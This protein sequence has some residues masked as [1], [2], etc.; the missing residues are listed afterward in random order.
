[1][2]LSQLAKQLKP[3]IVPW[4]EAAVRAGGGGGSGGGGGLVTHALDGAYHTGVLSSNK[5]PDALLVSGARALVSSLDVAAGATIDGVDLDVHA[6][7]P[8]A[9]HA[10][11]TVGGGLTLAGQQVAVGAGALI[12]V[13]ANTVG[14]SPGANFQF[15]G[16]GSGI[17]AGWRNVS[18]LAGNGLVH[19]AGVLA[20]D[21]ANTG[22]AGLSVEADVVRLTSSDNPGAAAK[23]LATSPS[24]SLQLRTLASNVAFLSGF[25]GAGYRIDY[26]VTEAGK[27]SAEFDNLTVRGRMRVYEL[28]I[29][30]IRATNGSVFVASASKAEQV[31]AE[32]GWTVNGSVLTF[33]GSNADFNGLFYRVQ[34]RAAADDDS[35]DLYHGFLAGDVI[36]AQRFAMDASGGFASMRQSNLRVGTVHSLW[37]YTAH[38][39]GGDVPVVTDDFVR[40]GSDREV[41]RQGSLYLT[42]DDSNAP[43]ID[44]VDG[45]ESHAAWNTPGKVK[46]RL[47]KLTGITDSDFGGTLSGY[48]LYGNNV[49]LKGQIVVTG[50]NAAT[51]DAVNVGL[52]GRVPTGGAAA[53]VNANTTTID[54]GRITTNS[55]TADRLSVTS[56]A[57]IT[58]NMGALTVDNLLTIGASGEIRQGTGTLGSNFTGLRVWRESSVGR[59]AGYNNNVQQWYAG[60]DGKLYA[61]AGNVRLDSS[62]ITIERDF[63]DGLRFMAGATVHGVI[64]A[65]SSAGREILR[66]TAKPPSGDGSVLLRAYRNNSSLMG[67]LHVNPPVGTGLSLPGTQHEI[68]AETTFFRVAGTILADGDNG[69]IAGTVGLTDQSSSPVSTGVGT[70]RMTGATA[71]NSTG[72][73]KVYVGTAAKYIPYFDTPN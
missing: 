29:Q 62:G 39:R 41:T 1:M 2:N 45:V 55:I 5:Y 11:V 14:V 70:V 42:A 22:A 35:R 21:V 68:L 17:A 56:L 9:H 13:G 36:R 32:S 6:G 3:L 7:N 66:M 61:A 31:S 18:E 15:V 10:R 49:Y 37:E 20:V 28:L 63:V 60:T 4:I 30:Q 43:F 23:V 33:N 46:V 69:G 53:D 16:T 19:S 51:T 25:A 40:L 48:G 73:I 64:E 59:I 65:L 24:G 52:A 12:A 27:A 47:G 72:F 57:A 34:T 71:R 26:G 50:G 54:G 38:W 58:G 67:A 44:I 8:D